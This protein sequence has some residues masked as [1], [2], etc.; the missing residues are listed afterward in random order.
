[1]TDSTIQADRPTAVRALLDKAKDRPVLGTILI[2]PGEEWVDVCGNA[3]LDFVCVDQM[4]TSL[5]WHDTARMV[6]AAKTWGTSGWVRLS[7]YP[8]GNL[9]QAEVMQRDVHKAIACGAEAVVA[10]VETVDDVKALVEVEHE[11]HRWIWSR[12]TT[13][14]THEIAVTPSFVPLIESLDGLKNL[15]EI[16]AVDGLESVFLGFG[17]IS[18]LMDVPNDLNNPVLQKVITDAVESCAE[19]GVTV[20]STAGYFPNAPAIRGAVDILQGL[21]VGIVWVPYP[22]YLA[23][24][25][26]RDVVLNV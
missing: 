10:S 4:V 17:D 1:M 5:G 22:T 8:W 16:A 24:E 26:Y 13:P 20:Q 2:T 6:R 18:R 11:D 23:Y 19:H 3:G 25:I 9:R 15:G 21:G 14:G 12:G 7:A